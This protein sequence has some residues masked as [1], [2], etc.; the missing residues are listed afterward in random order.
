[1]KLTADAV[2]FLTLLAAAAIT[3]GCNTQKR[4]QSHYADNVQVAVLDATPRQPALAVTPFA[5]DEAPKTHRT[6]AHLTVQGFA[7]DE[8]ILLNLLATK[9]RSLGAN[10][11]VILRAEQPFKGWPASATDQTLRIFRAHAIVFGP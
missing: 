10:G 1:M 11:L 8:G 2:A 7:K 6:I 9:A 4:I 5:L 3:C